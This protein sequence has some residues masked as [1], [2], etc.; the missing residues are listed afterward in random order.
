MKKRLCLQATIVIYL[1]ISR[2]MLQNFRPIVNEDG[3]LMMYRFQEIPW[4]SEEHPWNFAE[5]WPQV[6]GCSCPYCSF[7]YQY[8]VSTPTLLR[9]QF[10]CVQILAIFG[11][12]FYTI[13]IPIFMIR[14]IL[15]GTRQAY[16]AYDVD[17][18]LAEVSELR[19][20]LKNI[21]DIDEAA[22]TINQINTRKQD[23]EFF[24][25]RAVLDYRTPQAYLYQ[26]YRISMKYFKASKFHSLVLRRWCELTSYIESWL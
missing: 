23:A 3:E 16:Q 13:G 4:P 11:L 5:Q 25:A 26:A 14:M 18:I 24:Y 21:E 2:I 9:L 10:P 15:K 7:F 20:K 19:E 6:R 22:E 12:L 17:F 1:P 8:V